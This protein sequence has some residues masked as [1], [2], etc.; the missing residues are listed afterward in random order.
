MERPVKRQ[1]IT[2]DSFGTDDEDE[3][4]C[5]PNEL[6]QRRD[7][8]YKLEQ[9]RAR[10]SNKLKSRFEDIFAKY[11]KDFTGVGDEIDLRTGEVV[12]DNGHLQSIT[13]IQKFGEGDDD[14]DEDEDPRSSGNGRPDH[15]ISDKALGNGPSDAVAQ[16]NP[17]EVTG[18][19]P[20]SPRPGT[21]IGGPP[22]LP[23]MMHTAHEY[24]M[25]PGQPF[26]SLEYRHTQDVD[27]AWQ[28]PELPRSA[29]MSPRFGS[30]AQQHRFGM[31]KTTKVTRRSLLEPRSH[32]GDEEDVLLGVSDNVLGKKESP[33]IKN[34]FPAV[35]SSPNND[36][37]LN[38]MIQDVIEN[39]A[40][41]SPL[42]EQSRKGASGPKS[43][44]KPKMKPVRPETG[45]NGRMDEKQIGNNQRISTDKAK[46]VS[47]T[48]TDEA[49]PKY[50]KGRRRQTALTSPAKAVKICKARQ[51]KSHNEQ[52]TAGPIVQSDHSGLDEDSFLDITGKTPVKPARQMFYVEI[53]ARKIGQ[54]DT[55]S[56]DQDDDGLRTVDRGHLGA[57]V[58]DQK[59]QPPLYALSGPEERAANPPNQKC[60]VEPATSCLVPE[61]TK[62]RIDGRASEG[63]GS[64]PAFARADAEN[65]QSRKQKRMSAPAEINGLTLQDLR[66]T[67]P[68]TQAKERFERNVVDPNYAFSDEENLLPRI[69]RNNRRNTEPASRAS[70]A[71]G[72]VSRVGKNAQDVKL[73]RTTDARDA[74]DQE[75][76]IQAVRASPE[77]IVERE[78]A[79]P[80][81]EVSEPNQEQDSEQM[82]SDVPSI[83]PLSVSRRQT[84]R[85]RLGKPTVEQPKQ[86]SAENP[87]SRPLRSR[88]RNK[89]GDGVHG[90]SELG[91]ISAPAVASSSAVA[92]DDGTFPEPPETAESAPV[93]PSTPQPKSKSRSEKT[94]VS[95]SGLISLLSDD[96]DEEDEISF[97]L[98]DFTPSGHHRILALRP[99][100][101]QPAS[102]S[103]GKK[104][105]VASLLF[106]P[107]STSKVSKHNTPGLYNSE[108]KRRR[109]STNTLPGSV[110]KV[111]RESPRAPSPAASVIQTPGG[112]K[113]RCGEDGFR[114]ERDFCFVCISI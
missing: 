36:P 93:P 6:N 46:A 10:A 62:K 105:R 31:G 48:R 34:K 25:P 97:N 110:V 38:E 16:R 13:G 14:D 94:E 9:A 33:L 17:W 75:K 40:D 76:Q 43:P 84:R 83:V 86:E 92:E 71:V 29:F 22:G 63:Q 106:G 81:T 78:T 41:T 109:R 47:A 98:A 74:S 101:H 72:G 4:D 107:A 53:K 50:R 15:G 56:P 68:K 104:R 59:L 57:D 87:E 54:P 65:L 61:T 80:P 96:D 28:A 32:D 45:I 112:T 60:A 69:K 26:C 49:D 23:S 42:A 12:V 21:S 100:H 11:E 19:I 5:E 7:P 111:M 67:V 85:M 77:P 37:G 99:H 95:R 27:P 58:L 30:Q 20:H 82:V 113:R 103:T 35:G 88:Y 70:L 52:Q 2:L 51:P 79:T 73:P 114:C 8:V 64:D 39:I 24:S 44:A 108:R 90:T 91:N 1:R 102:A 66:P 3:L 55:F 89:P 18:S